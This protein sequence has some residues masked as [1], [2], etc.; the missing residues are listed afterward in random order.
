MGL[1]A[2]IRAIIMKNECTITD[3]IHTDDLNSLDS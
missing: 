3:R 2:F 1:K